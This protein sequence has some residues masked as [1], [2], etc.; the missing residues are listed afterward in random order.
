MTRRLNHYVCNKNPNFFINITIDYSIRIRKSVIFDRNQSSQMRYLDQ[1][2]RDGFVEINRGSDELIY[3]P[4]GKSRKLSN[5]EEQVQLQTYLNLIYDYGYPPSHIR[6]C[7]KI[8]IGS[9]TREGD[10][11]IYRDD[12][13][14]DPWIVIECKK[15]NV[16]NSVF[17]MAINQGFSYAAVT[18]AQF[19]WATSGDRNA[20][21]QFLE[22]NINERDKNRLDRIPKFKELK[23]PGSLLKRRLSRW[24]NSPITTDT[25]LYSSVL[26]ISMVAI[27]LAAVTYHQEIRD[28]LSPYWGRYNMDYSWI[29]HA[30]AIV[31]SLFSLAI[32]LVFMRSHVLFGKSE[33]RKR[34]I[35]LMIALILYLPVLLVSQ[36]MGNP[37]WWTPTSYMSRQY[38]ILLYIWPYV[39]SLPFQFMALYG[40]IWLS[41]RASKEN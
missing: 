14:L 1:A 32:G 5:P 35:Y 19:V 16:P 2:I 3:Q 24:L 20:V 38:P 11:L 9:S 27:S 23:R 39:K 29:F 40:L 36:R 13:A 33:G 37:Q 8:Q 6:V 30:L 41:S 21:F 4:Q 17:E 10:I 15:Q 18:N 7:E 26:L 28:L 34:F 25:I 31:A 22:Q 12:R